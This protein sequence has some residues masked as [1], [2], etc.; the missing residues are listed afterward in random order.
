MKKNELQE[1]FKS[2][3]STLAPREKQMVSVGSVVV[4]AAIFYFGIWSPYLE[5]VA[6]LRQRVQSSQKTLLWMRAADVEMKK[7]EG[8]TEQ[9]KQVTS[10]V[11]VLSDVQKQ[12]TQSGL[13]GAMTQLKQASNDTVE[14]HFKQVPFDKLMKMLTSLVKSEGVLIT[15]MS[16]IA[17]ETPG[18]V[19]A[20]ITLTLGNKN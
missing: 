8:E 10:P 9:Q 17:S 2:W 19:E 11:V 6:S 13:D 3:W 4:T 16:A 5:R 18:I 1:K 12:V 20:N 14:M 15:Q 7:M